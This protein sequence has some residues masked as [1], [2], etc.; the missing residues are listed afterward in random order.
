MGDSGSMGAQ[1]ACKPRPYII[2]GGNS[3]LLPFDF[4]ALFTFKIILMHEWVL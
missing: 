4:N 1:R 2:N 3:K